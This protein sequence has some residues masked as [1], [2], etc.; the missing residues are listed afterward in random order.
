MNQEELKKWEEKEKEKS[1][2]KC[3]RCHQNEKL[4]TIESE[5]DLRT[6][7]M[8]C[9]YRMSELD[10]PLNFN[11]NEYSIRVCKPCRADFMRAMEMWFNNPTDYR[12]YSMMKHLSG[13]KET[14]KPRF[15]IITKEKTNETY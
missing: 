15:D 4:E 1:K 9:F 3:W 6:I 5:I 13:H 8:S 12:N 2:H 14:H 7:R 10:I 11:G